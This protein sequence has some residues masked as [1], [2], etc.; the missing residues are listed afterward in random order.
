MV[1]ALGG[2]VSDADKVALTWELGAFLADNMRE[3]LRGGIWGWFD[4]DLAFTR[5]WG[6]RLSSIS[7]P[8]TVW[9]GGQDRM[10][11]FRHSE[12]LASRI[13]GA[14]ARLEPDHGHLSLAVG[15][16]GRILDD[17]LLR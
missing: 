10:V 9:H 14:R 5:D 4:D 11:P 15:S 6:F 2:L 16:F 1:E 13:P 3:G 7:V 8:V 17:L 12:W